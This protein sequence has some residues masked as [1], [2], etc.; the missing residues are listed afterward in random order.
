MIMEL[1]LLGLRAS[2]RCILLRNLAH[3]LLSCCVYVIIANN[4]FYIDVCNGLSIIDRELKVNGPS[5]PYYL[6]SH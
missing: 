2:M 4:V 5:G 1:L 6:S 3:V